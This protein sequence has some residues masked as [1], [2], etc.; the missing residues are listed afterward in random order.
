MLE[1]STQTRLL[2][3][4]FAKPNNYKQKTVEGLVFHC[5]PR[6]KKVSKNFSMSLTVNVNAD[7][8][9]QECAPRMKI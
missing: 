1:W 2:R 4:S 9:K 3:I 5:D 7:A 6:G 8:M